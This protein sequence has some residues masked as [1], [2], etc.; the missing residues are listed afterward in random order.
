MRKDDAGFSII[1]V[2][3]VATVTMI[4]VGLA[5]PSI[6]GAIDTYKFNSDVN[7]VAATI[8]A[9]RY[10]AVASNVAVRVRFNCPTTG[11]MRVVEVTGNAAIDDAAD[12]CDLVAY[13]YPDTDAA[14][15]PNN[16][17]PVLEMGESSDF[18][19]AIPSLHVTT[20]GRVSPLTGCPT[21]VVGGPPALLYI[22]DDRTDTRRLITVTATGG[23]TV[24]RH[25][26]Y[27]AQAD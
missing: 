3:V 10:K 12:R 6:T 25:A 1:E 21:C 9:A 8:R 7:A 14:N 27:G 22:E 18:A 5:A 19:G 13:P 26:T 23:T 24:S 16:D 17:G 15:A 11:Q 20:A 2:V 4:T